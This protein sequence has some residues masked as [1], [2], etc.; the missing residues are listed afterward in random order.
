M[1]M[2]VVVVMVKVMIMI[3]MVMIM[4]MMIMTGGWAFERLVHANGRSNSRNSAR[5]IE[6][7]KVAGV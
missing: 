7:R 5:R 1:V 4:M 2:I 3:M 6:V